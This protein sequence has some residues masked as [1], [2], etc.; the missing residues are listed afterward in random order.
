MGVFGN[1]PIKWSPENTAAPDMP[2][3]TL[4]DPLRCPS[5]LSRSPRPPA[6]LANRDHSTTARARVL[7][8]SGRWLVLHGT[9]FSGGHHTAVIIEAAPPAVVTPL[10]I[11]AYGLSDREQQ[12]VPLVLRGASTK[13]IAHV[14]SL[15][16]LTVQDHLKTIF[17]KMGIHS[18][19]QIAGRIFLDHYFPA[20][21]GNKT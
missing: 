5:K 17:D 12:I 10:I 1:T 19:R 11:E 8:K 21:F 9:R 6:H 14:L 3:Q 15:S 20:L 7:T 2:D 16:P 18:R 4:S 13:Q